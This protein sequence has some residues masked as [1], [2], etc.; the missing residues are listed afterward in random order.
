MF[1][2]VALRHRNGSQPA[3][4]PRTRRYCGRARCPPENHT[5][6]GRIVAKS[7]VASRIIGHGCD[8]EIRGVPDDG[9]ERLTGSV[10]E[11]TS[12]N[13]RLSRSRRD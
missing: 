5:C 9:H 11:H 7:T 8:R 6:V 3:N 1:G 13:Q 4:R 10:R 12:C 2:L